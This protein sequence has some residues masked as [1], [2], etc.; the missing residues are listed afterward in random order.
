MSEDDIRTKVV[1]PWLA[2][3]GFDPSE[4]S[5]EFSFEIRLGRSI[6]RVEGKGKKSPAGTQLGSGTTARPR[7]D[8]LVRRGRWNLMVVEVKA[9][10]ETVDD[11]ARDQGISYARLLPQIAPFVV[12]TNGQTSRVYDSITR[13]EITGTQIPSDHPGIRGGFNVSVDELALRAEAL[14][15]FV[16]LSAENLVAFC[17][18]QLDYRMRQLRDDDPAS[19]KKYI[20]NLYVD[21]PLP[22]VAIEEHLDCKHARTVAVFGRPQVGKTNFL[23][24]FAED[25]IRAGKPVLFYPAISLNAGLLQ[26]IGEDFG[27][28]LGDQS[29]ITTLASKLGQVLRRTGSRLTLIIDGWNEADLE[30]ARQIDRECERLCC[31][32]TAIQVVVSFTHSAARRLLVHGGNPSFVADAVGIGLHGFQIIETDPT[33]ASRQANW[34]SVVIDPYSHH[35][36]NEAYQKLGTHFRVTV[37]ASHNK[38]SDPYLLGVAMRH[39]AGRALPESMDEPELLRTW[40]E[41]RIARAPSDNLDARSALSALGRAVTIDGSPLLEQR[42]KECLGLSPLQP[43]PSSF[44]ELALISRLTGGSERYVDFYNSRDRDYVIA[45]WSLRWPER[46]R[47]RD[48]LWGEFAEVCRSRAGADSLAWFFRQGPHLTMLLDADGGLPAISDADLRRVFLSSV[49]QLSL[50]ENQDLNQHF[51]KW[52]KQCREY[53]AKDPDLRCRVEALK[54]M[55]GI[56]EE[57]DD[58]LAMIPSGEEQREFVRGLLEVMVEY[59][60]HK[61]G[62]GQ[63]VLDAFERLH[64]D[65]AADYEGEEDSPLTIILKEERA[66]CSLATRSVANGCLGRLMPRSYL[67]DLGKAIL[68]SAVPEEFLIGVDNAVSAITHMYWG[69][70]Y[71]TPYIQHLRLGENL[72]NGDYDERV[73]SHY[74]DEARALASIA[75]FTNIGD[76]KAELQDL[77][78][79]LRGLTPKVVVDEDL[80]VKEPQRDAP[81]QLYFFE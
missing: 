7:T 17:K 10:D 15:S 30:V 63:L 9:P 57:K 64:T 62:L 42:A 52:V 31:Q 34:S 80:F 14:E 65:E 44:C 1:Y 29:P 47:N 58:L 41:S 49:A 28:L 56:T 21:R 70:G 6:Y 2:G 75:R 61:G 73:P 51:E 72:Q 78:E 71:C 68:G 67:R 3:C 5:I 24:R 25:R 66:N 46:V 36:K 4:I 76:S 16:S 77:V 26:E 39:F 19:G 35:E 13:Q 33:A 54:L 37:D 79:E 43:I 8:V 50:S 69:D 20:P 12:V 27:W 22:R 74:N 38:T 60:P 48:N 40:I 55:A 32:G 11:E 53:G 45:C 81:G 18:M 59:D 23:C